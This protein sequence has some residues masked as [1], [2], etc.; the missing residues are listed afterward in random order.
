MSTRSCIGYVNESGKV[1][2]IYCHYDGY[3][4]GVGKILMDHYNTLESVKE[5]V[6]G[7]DASYIAGKC[8]KPEG[9]SYNTP[10]RGYTVYYGR[11]RGEK[12]VAKETHDTAKEF[13]TAAEDRGADYAYV[14][15]GEWVVVT[16]GKGSGIFQK[17][18]GAVEVES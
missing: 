5:L 13:L 16:I 6:A 7:G 15:N 14:F 10:V 8:S 2:S 9:H 17:L 4:E 12:D 11:D 1:V 3:P 18:K